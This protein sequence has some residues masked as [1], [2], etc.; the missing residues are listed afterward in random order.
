MAS[1]HGVVIT[2]GLA[3]WQIIQ[4]DTSGHGKIEIAGEWRSSDGAAGVVEVRLAFE[5]T[6]ASVNQA[7]HWTEAQTKSD[8]TWSATIDG[9]PAGGLYRLETRLNNAGRSRADWS[10]RGDVRHFLGVGDIWV[11]AGQ[12]NSA[13]YGRGSY[14]DPPEMGIHMLR[15][16]LEWSLA[17][18]PMNDST[19]TKHPVNSEGSTSGH[20]PYLNFARELK[21][22]L[23][24]PIGLIQTSLGGSP[25][26][27]W[28]PAEP[29]D[30]ALFHNMAECVRQAGGSVKGVL[31]YQ[32]ESDCDADSAR[33]YAYRFLAAVREWRVA[34]NNPT[35]AV[36]TVQL[37]R[38][39]VPC[40]EDT[41]W[42]IVREAQRQVA[43]S[44]RL[45]TIVPA[46]DLPLTD[47]IHNA[48]AGNMALGARMALSALQ[49]VYAKPVV[50]DAPDL[51][52]ARLVEERKTVELTFSPVVSM[53]S[54]LD[55]RIIP[56]RVVDDD[57]DVPIVA[58]KCPIDIGTSTLLASAANTIRLALGRP[59]HG[60]TR[61]HAAFGA[62]P[63]L[64][65][66]DM[67]R[68]MPILAFYDVEV[69]P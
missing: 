61:V 26:S 31:W 38:M 35:L 32:G 22:H 43:K 68:T 64:L 1:N 66:M 47:H 52:D 10:Q 63:P 24:Y 5:D 28:N 8:G 12:S 67:E 34:L 48:P 3:D 4:Q 42:S 45:V 46:L 58:M 50:G 60:K 15:N 18:H 36:I 65:P 27:A 56:F 2:A 11:I 40:A 25:L 54:T 6:S 49:R 55:D 44:D 62:N 37:N 69:Q 33:T 14:S 13:G 16:S 51:I 7:L 23:G 19:D 41:A 39:T 29:G 21:K 53:L 30:A 59:T 20:S 57:G 9:I 17:T